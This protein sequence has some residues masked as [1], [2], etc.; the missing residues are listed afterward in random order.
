M[1]KNIPMTKKKKKAT[2]Y[3]EFFGRYGSATNTFS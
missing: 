3:K 1:K 2:L